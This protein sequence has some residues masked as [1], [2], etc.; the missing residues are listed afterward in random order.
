MKLAL[1]TETTG[2]NMWTG[3]EPFAVSGFD[4]RGDEH[5]WEFDVHP[6]TRKVVRD[7]SKASKI[8]RLVDAASAVPMWHAKFDWQMLQKIGVVVPLY[9]IHEVT[10]KAK[11]CDNLEHSYELKKYAKKYADFPADDESELQSAVVASR[12]VA[13]ELGWSRGGDVKSDYWLPSTLWRLKPSKARAA[14]IPRDV[15]RRYAINDAKRTLILDDMLD[16]AMDELDVRHVY[17]LEMRLWPIVLDMERRGVT[18]NLGTMRRLRSQCKKIIRRDMEMLRK[19]SGNKDFNPNSSQQLAKFLYGG[20]EPII[21]VVGKRTAK[22]APKTDAEALMP[23]SAIPAVEAVLRLRA[24]NQAV[25][26][27]FNKYASVAEKLSDFSAILHP[28]YKQWGTLTGRFSCTEPNIQQVSDPNNSNSLAAQFMVDIRQVFEPPAGYVWYCPD[29]SQVEVVIFAEVSGEPF[30]MESI[31]RGDDI[32]AAT[33]ERVWGGEGNPRGVA[34]AMLVLDTR[35]RGLALAKLQEHGWKITELE[36]SVGKKLIR[37]RAKS[38]TFTKIFGGG[39][40]ALMRWIS[41]SFDEAVEVLAAYDETFT[42]IREKMADIERQG[43]RDGYVR[44][45]YGRRLSVT[46][47]DAYKAVNH[48]VQSTAADLIKRGMV[49]CAAYLRALRRDRGV[50]ARIAMTIH[51]ELVFEFKAGHDDPRILKGI[52]AR[53]ADT[54]GVMKLPVEVGIDRVVRRWSEKE[55]VRFDA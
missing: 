13:A 52:A 2:L 48:V 55:K 17:E 43:R 45:L 3:A 37:K 35:D 18:I 28:G 54:G 20:A 10:F 23:H 26:L 53:M 30:M 39:P 36:K 7:E 16:P 15:C 1:D 42:L 25:K 41:V 33:A 24:N 44:S 22:G 51:D 47:W 32:H 38:V 14:R 11:A 19:L 34:A 21:P 31:R 50:D 4:S 40:K 46:R 5:Y 29:Y 9:K 6:R 49:K 12:R 27:F 8:Q